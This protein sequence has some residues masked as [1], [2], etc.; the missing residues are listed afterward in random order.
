M[1][2]QLDGRRAQVYIESMIVEVSGSN[3]A[4][5]GFQW[6]GMLGDKG[7]KNI[8]VG[9]TNLP[10]SAGNVGTNAIVPLAAAVA[11]GTRRPRRR[12]RRRCRA[13]STSASS[14]TTAASTASRRS[15][16]SCSRR[17]TPTS[18]RRRTW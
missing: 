17:R 1:I 13:A 12:L 2:E 5:F 9:G 14:A 7:D 16:S 18:P 4:D 11:G 8:V 3:E 10:T 6:Q 15:P